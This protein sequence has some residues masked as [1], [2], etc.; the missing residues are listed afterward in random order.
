MAFRK[1]P[2]YKAGMRTNQQ[3]LFLLFLL[4]GPAARSMEPQPAPDWVV[5][6]WKNLIGVWIAD[7]SAYKK[8]WG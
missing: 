1:R 6:N 4:A 5:T 7:N 2:A 3:F 8:N